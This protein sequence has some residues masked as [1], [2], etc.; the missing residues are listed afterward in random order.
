MEQNPQCWTNHHSVV[1]FKGKWYLFYHH[2]DYSP[3]FDKNRSVCVDEITFNDDGSINLVVPT[4]RGV[5]VTKATSQIQIDRYSNI[6]DS[7]HAWI[8]FLRTEAPFE[9]WKTVFRNNDSSRNP[10]WVEYDRVDFANTKLA[11]IVVRCQSNVGGT[12]EV[13]A[14]SLNGPVI[15]RV[16]IAGRPE[17]QDVKSPVL[18]QLEGVHDLF[19]TM[20]SGL[21]MYIDWIKFSE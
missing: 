14:D 3:N 17:W 2:N 5:G 20:R 1:E 6:A 8:E 16:D 15:A 13:H 18:S 12:V 4:K 19:V 10:I 7:N 11:N 9:G 21:L